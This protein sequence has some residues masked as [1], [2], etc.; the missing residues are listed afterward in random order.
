MPDGN[1]A[2][3]AGESLHEERH[4]YTRRR[5]MRKSRKPR[6]GSS[7]KDGHCGCGSPAVRLSFWRYY[8][9]IP[10]VITAFKTESPDDAYVNGHVTFVAPRCLV[11]S[12]VCW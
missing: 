10:W 7:L 1:S 4:L 12:C 9:A 2:E 11:K 8:E 5:Q 6:S 3:S